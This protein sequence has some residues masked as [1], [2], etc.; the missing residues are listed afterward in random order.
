MRWPL[1]VIGE[2]KQ[3]HTPAEAT[4]PRG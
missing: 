4:E 3:A 1:W 2:N